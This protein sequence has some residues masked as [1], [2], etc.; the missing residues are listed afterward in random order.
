MVRRVMKKLL[1]TFVGEHLDRERIDPVGRRALRLLRVGHATRL[2]DQL[3]GA[4][5]LD[6]VRLLLRHGM[7]VRVIH[8]LGA[9]L[10]PN[11]PALIDERRSVTYAEANREINRLG[12]ALRDRFGVSVGSSVALSTEN[13]A[14]YLLTWF[15][16]LRLGARA[17][18]ASYR[19]TAPELEYQL[20]HSGARVLLVSESSLAVA[21][22]VRDALPAPGIHLVVCGA[23][24][25]PARG[26]VSY[27]ELVAGGDEQPLPPPRH[28]SGGGSV[29]YTSGTTGKPKGAV[30]DFV[31]F[32]PRELVR[33][34]ERLPLRFGEQHVAAAPLY[35]SAPQVF[36]LLTAALGGTLRLLPHFDAEATLRALSEQA[37]TSVFLVPTMLRRVLELPPETLG[38]WPMP[39]LRAVVVGS[40]EF[41]P[42]LREAAIA[43]FGAGAV[44]DFYGATELGWVT[45]I[46]G[47]EMLQRP[48]SVGRPLAGQRIRIHAPD[49]RALPVGE[50]GLI[51]V[52]NDQT[53][54][55]YLDDNAASTEA[56]REAGVT[57]ED[58]GRV[59]RD[60]YLYLAG[61]AR[62]MVKS[63]GV[64]VYPVE[65]EDV[66]ARDPAIREVAVIGVPDAEWGE[67]LVGVVVPRSLPFDADAVEQRARESLSSLKVP[68][69]WEV[70]D[71]LPR[72]A[73]GKVLKTELRARF[74]KPQG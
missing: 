72:N 62:D 45:L 68:R 39:S 6:L 4:R 40:A 57:V 73:T 74:S 44:F 69:R 20:R 21:R 65:I 18:H 1:R 3:T 36:A 60:G 32:G 38:R 5:P 23:T 48:G 25:D 16:L 27:E 41:A 14:E 19:L 22:R 7:N 28:G 50:V 67:R 37:A 51:H 15:A 66:L 59:D 13:R 64:N 11:R 34:L 8:A 17:V 55:G 56:R 33:L 10:H 2:R 46:R 30:R 61:R 70:L 43:R 58:L 63:G 54:R 9:Q 42:P 29:V 12:S 31:S 24:P 71:E 52:R 49:G 35:H 53:M 26:E 47:D